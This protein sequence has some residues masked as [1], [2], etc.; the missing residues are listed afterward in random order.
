MKK[1]ISTAAVTAIA[2]TAVATVLTAGASAGN[3]T[4]ITQTPASTKPFAGSYS[5]TFARSASGIINETNRVNSAGA[6]NGWTSAD[7]WLQFR[8][9]SNP[10]DGNHVVPNPTC[11]ATG[12][13]TQLTYVGG[14]DPEITGNAT[15][16]YFLPGV[17]YNACVYLV[18][19]VVG[20]GMIDSSNPNGTTTNLPLSGHFRINVSGTYQNNSLNVADAEYTGIPDWSN[21]SDG[22]NVG[23][24]QL[25]E[26][27]GDVQVNGGFVNWGAYSATHAY[28]L[29]GAYSGS[30]NLA[31]FD[32]D[33]NTNTKTPG[34]YGD[35]TGSLN[36]TITYLGL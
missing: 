15:S 5:A 11:D 9:T 29:T 27:F 23:Q 13:V 25:G 32:G 18:N 30:V 14:T 17:A 12:L 22:Y 26:G 34:W 20:S 36:Y 33:S 8:P 4:G 6:Q 2:V 7:V 21:Q 35:N 19:P 3:G 24:F 1:W 16:G 28:S 10:T 31:V